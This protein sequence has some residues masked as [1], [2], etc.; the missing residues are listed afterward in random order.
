MHDLLIALCAVVGL[1]LLAY[2]FLPDC[3]TCHRAFAGHLTVTDEG[4]YRWLCGKCARHVKRMHAARAN[5]LAE[6]K[7][8]H[9][10][11]AKQTPHTN[12]HHGE[13]A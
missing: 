10:A 9:H 2:R 5:S 11:R 4:R 6:L 12:N 13:T 7:G 3:F 1:L 8:R